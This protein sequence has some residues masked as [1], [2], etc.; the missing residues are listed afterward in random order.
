VLTAY[1]CFCRWLYWVEAEVEKLSDWTIC[2]D[3]EYR[4]AYDFYLNDN[5]NILFSLHE[6]VSIW[7][8]NIEY[9][10]FS[11]L[12]VNINTNKMYKYRICKTKT[13]N[14]TKEIKSVFTFENNSKS[15]L[16]EV[17]NGSNNLMHV[18]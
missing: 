8:I 4:S 12:N 18:S 10:D 16:K 5:C 17:I 9:E 7:S 11:K 13:Q 1:L 6:I 3:L 15:E 2:D 14:T